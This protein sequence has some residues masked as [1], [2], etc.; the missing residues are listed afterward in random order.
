MSRSLLN[1]T[2]VLICIVIVGW[3]LVV[4]RHLLVPF[5][6]AMIVWYV[7]DTVADAFS[8]NPIG[9]PIPRWL[10]IPLSMTIISI[11]VYF[12]FSLIRQNISEFVG[13]APFYQERLKNLL[14]QLSN[15]FDLSD[16]DVMQTLIPQLNITKIATGLASI[17]SNFLSSLGLVLIY[18][19][20][21]L[22]EQSAINGKFN[23]LFSGRDQ[24]HLAVSIREKIVNSIRHYVSIKTVV[25]L[26]TAVISYTVLAIVGVKY[27]VLFAVIIFLLNYIP[28]IGSLI[29]VLFPSLMALLQ[30]DSIWP[31]V[32][33]VVMLGMAQF[34]IG[35]FVE[36]RLMGKTLNLSPLVILLSLSLWGSIWG[37]TG[38]VLCIPLTV[39]MLIVCAQFQISRPIAILLSANGKID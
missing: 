11:T 18:V 3:L 32:A 38:M 26:L 5:A 23:A 30:Y 8:D 7:I 27:A 39:M 35:N 22:F 29:G 1:I 2:L 33:V 21:L 12:L 13:D 19:L 14:L 28:T 25:S 34:F 24:A 6:I 16:A 9:I 4:G 31:F 36:P 17:T 15:I 10:T 37:V 20:F